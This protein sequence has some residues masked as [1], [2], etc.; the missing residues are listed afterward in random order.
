MTSPLL[1]K[2]HR[3]AFDIYDRDR[4]GKIRQAD[5]KGLALA[6]AKARGQS[7][8]SEEATGLIE[9][10][11]LVW[12]S[13]SP[14]DHDKDGVIGFEEYLAGSL[15]LIAD[16]DVYRANQDDRIKFIFD[17]FDTN[18][19][20]QITLDEYEQFFD[21]C[22]LDKAAAAGCFAKL[23][24]NADGRLTR[25]E[26]VAADFEYSTSDDVNARGNWLLGPIAI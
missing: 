1:L 6:L 5:F 22:G 2:K 4:D 14:V 24:L 10:F 17:L 11:D 13:L 19:D 3:A 25:D 12:Q 16:K 9:R 20:G 7:A 26:V 18:A 8:E 23:D 21:A 15:A